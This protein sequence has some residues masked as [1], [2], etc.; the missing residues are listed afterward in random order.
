MPFDKQNIPIKRVAL[1]SGNYNCVVDGAN[2]ALNQL[3]SF[4]EKKDINVQVFAPTCRNPAF[5]PAGNLNSVP[6]IPIPGRSEYRV[7]CGLTP[8]LK[9]QLLEFDPDIIHL[10]A[11]DIL[12]NS[13][14]KWGKQ[15]K[16]PVVASF[17]TRFDTY[18][19]YYH[20][21]WLEKYLIR[22][23]KTFYS[24]CD[25]VYS[26]ADCITDFLK[27]HDMSQNIRRWGRGIDTDLFNPN[28]RDMAWRQSLGIKP[29]EKVILFVGRLVLEKGLDVYAQILDSLTTKGITHKA[30][31]VGEGPERDAFQR[32]LPNAIF[33]GFQNGENLARAYASSDIFVNPSIT[34][35]FGNVTLEAMASGVPA[36]CADASGARVI[37]KP[38]VTGFLVSP[39][40]IDAY[41]NKIEEFINNDTLHQQFCLASERHSQNLTWESVLSELFAQY[42]EVVETYSAQTKLSPSYIHRSL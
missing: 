20:M 36:I 2:R 28:K 15:N 6:S 19:R 7:A 25:Q 4:L 34:E 24:Q 37:V 31:I 41:V 16:I 32:R 40:N 29:E 30:L 11:P 12:G 14:L 39:K 22:Y 3:V 17:H 5:K 42:E 13:A 38:D 33:T 21:A 9:H 1:F 27:E 18:P 26:P 35:A 10:S 8:K 23:M